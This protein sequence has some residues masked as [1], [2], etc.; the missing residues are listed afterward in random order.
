MRSKRSR[1]R[2]DRKLAIGRALVGLR[3][4][5]PAQRQSRQTR[6]RVESNASAIYVF[7]SSSGRVPKKAMSLLKVSSWLL[8][9]SSSPSGHFRHQTCLPIGHSAPCPV[10]Q[11]GQKI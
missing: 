2:T 10:P 8:I 1:R 7:S 3:L 5:P 11:Y 9:S 4:C 6:L